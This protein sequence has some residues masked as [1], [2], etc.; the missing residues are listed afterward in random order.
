MNRDKYSGDYR[1]CDNVVDGRIVQTAE[2]IGEYY[3]FQTQG[4][5]RRPIA[6][7]LLVFCIVG[8]FAC[9]LPVS[10]TNRLSTVIYAIIP[11]LLTAIPLWL[12]MASLMRIR[13]GK[14]PM[15]HEHADKAVKYFAIGAP[16]A[17]LTAGLAVLG[18]MV[19]MV[20]HFGDNT[21]G[22][23]LVFVICDIIILIAGI[24]CLLNRSISEVAVMRD[25]SSDA[26]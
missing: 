6:A 21:S 26:L 16:F 11:H 24:Y 10:I 19:W 4:E 12:L 17:A 7:R 3:R 8:I 22:G 14:E 5:R 9:I 23:D 18:D 20:S 2:Y 13:F 1:L 15:I 25:I